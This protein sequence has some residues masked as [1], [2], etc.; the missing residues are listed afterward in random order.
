VRTCAERLFGRFTAPTQ[1][2]FV[3]QFQ[4]VALTVDQYEI[5]FDV[6]RTI[7][8]GNNRGFSHFQLLNQ[9]QSSHLDHSTERSG[10]ERRLI[11]PRIL[12]EWRRLTRQIFLPYEVGSYGSVRTQCSASIFTIKSARNVDLLSMKSNIKPT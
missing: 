3:S 5:A 11:K 12:C 8:A 1:P 7:I 6:V 2:S 10:S 9:V 4:L